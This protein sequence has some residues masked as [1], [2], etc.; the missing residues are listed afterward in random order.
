MISALST[1]ISL[2]VK[3]MSVHTSCLELLANKPMSPSGDLAFSWRAVMIFQMG[4]CKMSVIVGVWCKR[5]HPG[6]C[7]GRKKVATNIKCDSTTQLFGFAARSLQ[8]VFNRKPDVNERHTCLH[9]YNSF[10]L[11]SRVWLPCPSSRTPSFCRPSPYFR[12]AAKT[13]HEG[14][15]LD[16]TG[17]IKR[18]NLRVQVY[19]WNLG[20]YWT[21]QRLN[22][23]V[24][25]CFLLCQLLRYFWLTANR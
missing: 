5:N 20:R 18:V 23:R 13:L 19:F 14:G 15:T 2:D 17:P 12:R 22:S 8:L 1:Q 11:D 25:I 16:Q 3:I 24:F 7:V 10:P 6:S 9:L 21:H 4:Q